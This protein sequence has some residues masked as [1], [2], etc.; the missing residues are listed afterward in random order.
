MTQRSTPVTA[1]MTQGNV[2]IVKVVSRAEDDNGTAVLRVIVDFYDGNTPDINNGTIWLY[3]PVTLVDAS[4][5]PSG[6]L[7]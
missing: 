2:G 1:E 5:T 7:T 3:R 4:I 6:D